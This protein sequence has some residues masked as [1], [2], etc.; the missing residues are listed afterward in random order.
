MIIQEVIFDSNV[1]DWSINSSTFDERIINKENVVII[2]ETEDNI[3]IG[4]YIHNKINEVDKYVEDSNSFIFTIRE[5]INEKY[6]KPSFP[7]FL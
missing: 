2:I 4:G 3:K 7:I 1:C 6:F 5:N